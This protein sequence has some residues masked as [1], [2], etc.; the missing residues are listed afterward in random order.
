M[1]NILNIITDVYVW[2][3]IQK[4][5]KTAVWVQ[6]LVSNSTKSTRQKCNHW[7]GMVDLEELQQKPADWASVKSTNIPESYK[8]F[9]ITKVQFRGQKYF[10][11]FK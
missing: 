7:E 8:V 10:Q 6:I 11:M 1:N 3:S 5:Y 4:S 2:L 9:F